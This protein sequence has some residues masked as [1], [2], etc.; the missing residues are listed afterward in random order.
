MYLAEIEVHFQKMKQIGTQME[1]VATFLQE[2]TEEEGTQI[3]TDVEKV[4]ESEST[5]VFRK[6]WTLQLDKLEES[7]RSLKILS[8]DVCQKANRFYEAEKRNEVRA[9]NRNYFGF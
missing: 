1:A 7:V 6:V 4:W 9:V 3:A 8:A 5:G 2:L